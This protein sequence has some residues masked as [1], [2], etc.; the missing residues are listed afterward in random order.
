M[1]KMKKRSVI[2]GWI[3]FALAM[4]LILVTSASADIKKPPGFPTRA[5]EISVGFGVGGGVDTMARTIAPMLEKRMGVPI[6]IVN[7][8]GANTAVCMAHLVNQPADGYTIGATANDSVIAMASGLSKLHIDDFEWLARSL[9]DLEMFFVRSDDKRFKTWEEYFKYAKA[10]PNKLTMSVGGAEGIE[11]IVATL[12]NMAAGLSIKY[13]PFDKPT[14][15]YAAF[16]GGHTD[17]LLDEPPDMFSY[18]QEGKV[19]PIIQMI[20]K[21]PEEFKDVPTTVEKGFD[22]TMSVWRGFFVKK[23]TP[24]EISQYL[25]AVFRDCF[26]DPIWLDYKKKRLFIRP[27]FKENSA[28]FGK[29]AAKELE[30][31]KKTLDLIRKDKKS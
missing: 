2:G 18:L 13:I 1:K 30:V 14:E 24:P 9:N 19:H 23:G 11:Q 4:F 25:E 5:I 21:R 17:L 22:V 12:V 28:E 31:I 7:R 3:V 26:Q 6:S 8:P 20:D 15:R 10:N 29:S 27:D 16:L